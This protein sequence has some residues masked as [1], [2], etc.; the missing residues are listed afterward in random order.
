MKNNDTKKYDVLSPD[1][2]SITGPHGEYFNSHRE[3]LEGFEKWKKNFEF[4][5]YYST[6]R[7]EHIPL[8]ELDKYCKIVRVK[9]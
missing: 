1:G 5:G 6:G 8:D 9:E 4:Q 3:A 7:L 2:L